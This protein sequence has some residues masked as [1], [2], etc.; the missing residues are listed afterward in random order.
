VLHGAPKLVIQNQNNSA[1]NVVFVDLSS[2]ENAW[3]SLEQRSAK[4]ENRGKCKVP[5]R[6]VNVLAYMKETI[7]S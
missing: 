7:K 1:N 6:I 2:V 5:S 3:S 4:H